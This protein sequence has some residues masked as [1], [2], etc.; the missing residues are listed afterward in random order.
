MPPA[1]TSTRTPTP[2]PTQ[3]PTATPVPPTATLTAT[4]T[5]TP[6]PSATA[7]ATFTPSPT[8]TPLPRW[9]LKIVANPVTAGKI[10]FVPLPDIDGKYAHG[11]GITVL[12]QPATTN[13]T[14]VNWT[15]TI[16]STNAKIG[17]RIGQNTS[18]V[19]NFKCLIISLSPII[20]KS[21][22]FALPTPTPTSTFR[23]IG[24]TETIYQ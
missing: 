14:F 6:T 7:T 2:T 4:Q 17:F 15:G 10:S 11:T 5:N 3:A 21:P 22:I 20:F 23:Q 1:A 9:T 16:A 24:A 19:A 8:L 12:A 13:C 18:L